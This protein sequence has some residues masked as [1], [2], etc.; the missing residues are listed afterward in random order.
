M[1][2]KYTC[3]LESVIERFA[4]LSRTVSTEEQHINPARTVPMAITGQSDSGIDREE[5]VNSA[6]TGSC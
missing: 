2:E 1:R 6:I 3:H 4:Y 5:Q